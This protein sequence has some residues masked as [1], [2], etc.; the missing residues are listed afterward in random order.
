M[1]YPVSLLQVDHIAGVLLKA[2]PVIG[3]EPLL[4]LRLKLYGSFLGLPLRTLLPMPA[5]GVQ[6]I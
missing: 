1:L 5:G 2:L 3:L 4:D 6:V